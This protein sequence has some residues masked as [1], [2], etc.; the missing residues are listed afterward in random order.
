MH[1]SIE[2]DGLWLDMNEASNFCTGACYESQKAKSPLFY[3]LPYV[4]SG[5]DLEEK[6]LALDGLHYGNVTELDAHSLFGSMEVM[7]THE[8]FEMK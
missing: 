6:S 2:F 7:T 1:K 4:P 5:R 3:N 8:W